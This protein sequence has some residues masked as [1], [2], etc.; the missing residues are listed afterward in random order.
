MRSLNLNLL[1]HNGYDGIGLLLTA[2]S[3]FALMSAKVVIA[4]LAS[5]LAWLGYWT[6]KRFCSMS[7]DNLAQQ[8]QGDCQHPYSQCETAF[9]KATTRL[10]KT[11]TFFCLLTRLEVL[12]VIALFSDAERSD[13][14]SLIET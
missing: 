2:T 4:W 11:N 9:N 8:L 12:F 5:S 13:F 7:A 3:T 6:T 10:G 1:D 14:F